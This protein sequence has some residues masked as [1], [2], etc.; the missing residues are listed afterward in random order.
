MQPRTDAGNVVGNVYDK[1]RARN[2]IVRRL[3]QGFLRATTELYAEAA[4]RTVLEVGCGEGELSLR[5]LHHHRASFG[6]DPQRFEATDVDVSQVTAELDAAISVRE[7]SIYELPYDAD[8]FDLVVCCEV[9][10]HLRDPAAGVAELSRVARRHVLVSTP[11]EPVWRAMNMA[12][13]KY[14]REL[15]NTP[16]H[17]QHF[18]RSGLQSLAERH[19]QI[20][21]RR[22]PLPW[23]MLLG[24]PR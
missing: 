13:G 14:L 24:T 11:W 15:G 5:L 4:P 21:G 18:T 6:A 2:P 3:M 12:R 20:V 7:A 16:G 10:E 17:V 1:Y 9:L 19:L 23:T 22:T 8:A